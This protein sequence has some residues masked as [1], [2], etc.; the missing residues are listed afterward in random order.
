MPATLTPQLDPSSSGEHH[1]GLDGP[2]GSTK[3]S[4]IKQET[5]LGRPEGEWANALTHG[6]ATVAT[7]GLGTWMIV[8]AMPMSVGLAVACFVYALSVAATFS[9]STTSHVLT[10]Q[11][12]LDR[13]RAWDQ[14]MIYA[15]I[16]GTYTP[17]IYRFAPDAVRMPLLITLWV[18]TF[19]GILAKLVMHH[20]I[21]NVATITYLLL[22][23]IPAI[24]MFPH[25]PLGLGLGMALGGVVY[26]LAVIALVNDHRARY[27]HALWH[28]LVMAAAYCHFATI[29]RYVL[30]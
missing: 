5:A 24:P 17:V 28:V 15:M 16:S 3:A 8:E 30:V 18:V 26:S 27:L 4:V 25:V 29:W 19:A 9:A 22:G 6:L 14:A 13:A 12:M 21:N 2:S 20:R 10:Q 1:V 11:P 7:F 23:W